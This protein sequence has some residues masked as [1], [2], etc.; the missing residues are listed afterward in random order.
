MKN[1]RNGLSIFIRSSLSLQ[2]L[3]PFDID[4]KRKHWRK[5]NQ[6]TLHSVCMCACVCEWELC[7]GHFIH[8]R[9]TNS[10][11]PIHIYIGCTHSVI[12]IFI[13]CWLDVCGTQMPKRIRNG[14]YVRRKCLMRL[15]SHI[16]THTRTQLNENECHANLADIFNLMKSIGK[17]CPTHSAFAC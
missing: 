4:K 2:A 9:I 10:P 8:V 3:H 14:I 11:A 15:L 5:H 13:V 16:H 1:E 6:R 12:S 7:D 17:T